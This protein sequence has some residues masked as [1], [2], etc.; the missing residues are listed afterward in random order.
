L[1]GSLA[2][3]FITGRWSVSIDFDLPAFWTNK[4]KGMRM[5]PELVYFKPEEVVGLD[6]ELCA[7]LDL[8]RG[9]AGVPFTITCGLRTQAQNDALAGS[10]VKDSAHLTGHA[11]DLACSDSASRFAMIKALLGVGF[12]RIGVYSA[13]VHVDNSK[14]L[15][16]NVI[17]YAQGA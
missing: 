2:A 10:S 4:K 15:P 3:G 13:H 8:A 17:W 9:H 1:A 7:M 16:Q 14:T 12:T 11:V 5:P 6:Q